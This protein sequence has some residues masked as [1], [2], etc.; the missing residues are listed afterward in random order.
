MDLAEILHRDGGMSHRI[1]IGGDRPRGPARAAE[2]PPLHLGAIR[3]T[4]GYES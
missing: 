2:N 3:Q 1:L 4:S